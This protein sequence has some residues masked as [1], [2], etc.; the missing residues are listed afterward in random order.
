MIRLALVTLAVPAAACGST[1]V[2]PSTPA[3][4][5]PS[6]V[7]PSGVDPT[8]FS[9]KQV[10]GRLAPERIR[11]V[12]VEH[13]EVFGKCYEDGRRTN[14]KLQGKV[15]VKFEIDQDGTVTKSADARSDLPDEA[16]VK[17]VVD[18]YRTLRFPRPDA[19]VVTVYFP[20]IFNPRD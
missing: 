18:A 8:F 20:L 17:C 13:L 12:V 6:G 4:I 10:R 1:V 11:S 15:T 5:A 9:G 19:G 16:V 3:E 7:T 14:P 2:V